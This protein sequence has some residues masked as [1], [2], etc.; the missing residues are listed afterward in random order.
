MLLNIIVIAGRTPI[1]QISFNREYRLL[2]YCAVEAFDQQ[3]SGLSRL[4]LKRENRV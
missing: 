2:Q 4:L 1:S 3:P